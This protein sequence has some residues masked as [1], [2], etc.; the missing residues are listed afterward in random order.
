[1]SVSTYSNNLTNHANYF[2]PGAPK[3]MMS[4]K[5]RSVYSTIIAMDLK[6]Q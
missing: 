3:P 6:D 5:H 4:Q 1:M 2:F